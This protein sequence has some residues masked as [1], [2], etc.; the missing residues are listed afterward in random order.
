MIPL[1][2]SNSVDPSV[3]E[4]INMAMAMPPWKPKC[5]MVEASARAMISE[6]TW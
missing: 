4:K 5:A 3:I 6:F 2:K 1:S